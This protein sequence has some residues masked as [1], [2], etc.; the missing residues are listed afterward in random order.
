MKKLLFCLL[1][2]HCMMAIAQPTAYTVANAHSH[3][4]YEK[5][6]PFRAAYKEGF[7]SVEADLHLINDTLWVAHDK[8]KPGMVVPTFDKLYLQ[9]LNKEVAQQDGFPYADHTK[10]LQLLIDLKTTAIPTLNKVVTVLE[11]YPA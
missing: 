8:P 6:F 10:K 9:P 2:S 1:S 11:Q 3:N 5:P 7:G 4:D